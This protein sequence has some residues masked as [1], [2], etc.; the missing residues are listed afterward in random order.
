[1]VQKETL[2]FGTGGVPH[3]TPLGSNVGGIRRI[4]E[5]G[6]GCMEMEFVRQ[7]KMGQSTTR[8]VAVVARETGVRLS[9]HAPYYINLNSREPEKVT[10]SQARL[11][12]TARI[13][14]ACGARS[15]VFHAAFYLGDS[16]DK[17]YD[18]VRQK[19]SEVLVQVKKEG[20]QVDI[21]PEV[22]GKGSEFGTVE[23]ICRLSQEIPG[24]KPA[25][26][27]AHLH[28]REGNFNTYDEYIVVFDRIGRLLGLKALK[29]LHIHLSGIRY[30]AKGEISHLDLAESDL[31]YRD[32]LRALRDV[33]AAGS[34]VCESPNL[35]QDAL[36]L[37]ETYRGLLQSTM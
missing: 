18:V 13:A 27:V 25:V 17:A 19:L 30:G 24:V 2:V 10:A 15:V 4:S 9:A 6:L 29:D 1:M 16:Q 26:D 36:L 28:A 11:L 33:G 20:L 23:E 21:R 35:E 7:A 31:N 5:L 3:S 34:V 8:E 37:Q 32:L 14:A 12:Q 22:M